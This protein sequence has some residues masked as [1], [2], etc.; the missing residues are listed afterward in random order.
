[1]GVILCDGVTGHVAPFSIIVKKEYNPFY[2]FVPA[3]R[4]LASHAV[5]NCVPCPDLLCS[6]EINGHLKT[7]DDRMKNYL[8]GYG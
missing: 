5:P 8:N 1:M 6:G 3:G 4:S 2:R 7:G